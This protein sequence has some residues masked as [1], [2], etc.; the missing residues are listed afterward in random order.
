MRQ[1]VTIG[2]HA[3]TPE[4]S[5]RSRQTASEAAALAHV[6]AWFER[7]IFGPLRAEGPPAERLARMLDATEAY[8]L[9]GGRVCLVGAFALDDARDVFAEAVEG[10]FGAWRGA[11]A[12]VFGAAGVS[13]EQAWAYAE[14]VVAG[15]QGALVLSRAL[16]EAGVFRA[17]VGGE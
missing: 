1:A 10:Y 4:P 3:S 7:E 2:S 5:R 13:E 6:R 17:R 8:F 9:A 14:E 11:L 15:I 12:E 16:G